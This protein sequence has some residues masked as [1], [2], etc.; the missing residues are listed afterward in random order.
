MSVGIVSTC[1]PTMRP[2]LRLALHTVGLGTNDAAARSASAAGISSSKGGVA[3]RS[4]SRLSVDGKRARNNDFHRL[5]DDADYGSHVSSLETPMEDRLRPDGKGFTV[6]TVSNDVGKDVEF[7]DEIPLQGI[8]V[9]RQ[10]RST[11]DDDFGK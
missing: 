7:G 4:G 8:R 11:D 10:F 9:Q 2:V 6:T 1:L 5:G 3:R